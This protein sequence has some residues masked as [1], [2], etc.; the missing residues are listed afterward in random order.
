MQRG[1]RE[2]ETRFLQ[3]TLQR[4]GD[5]IFF[6]HPLARA[7]FTLNAGS[8]AILS[9]C[10]VATAENQQI[11]F[12]T[13]DEYTSG[14]RHCKWREIIRKKSLS[15]LREWVFST[16]TGPQESKERLKKIGN[17]RKNIVGAY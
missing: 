3:F 8:P 11:L 1:T 9:E 14:V 17:T 16:T 7:V 4:P 2:R 6:P 5:L 15:A 10:D 13:L 12:Q